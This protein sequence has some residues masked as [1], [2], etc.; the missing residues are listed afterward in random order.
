MPRKIETNEDL[1]LDLI[2][3]SPY[4]ALCQVFVMEAIQ[5]YARRLVKNPLRPSGPDALFSNETWNK[6]AV[7][8]KAR[9]D[10]FYGRAP[11]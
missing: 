4:G 5:D 1:V 6:V 8:V 11:S 10:A 9:C 7:D 2:N 3:Y